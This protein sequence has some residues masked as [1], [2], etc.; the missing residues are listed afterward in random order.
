[1]TISK[2]Q[3]QI[4]R[5]S[6]RAINNTSRLKLDIGSKSSIPIVPQYSS[7][8]A[9]YK[10]IPKT[11]PLGNLYTRGLPDSACIDRFENA[12]QLAE[13]TQSIKIRGYINLSIK[14]ETFLIID[15]EKERNSCRY[16]TITTNDATTTITTTSNF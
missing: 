16:T 2:K 14:P 13:V 10:R 3:F 6:T 12:K 1:M 9:L 7:V 5:V 11:C 15:K 4:R 8:E